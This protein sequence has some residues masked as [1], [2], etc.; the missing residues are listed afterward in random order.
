M[1]RLS[2]TAIG[3]YAL[4][5]L[6]AASS[7]SAY[8]RMTA[9]QRAAGPNECITEGAEL[10]WKQRC[11]SYSIFRAGSRDL[12]M[13]QL[14]SVMRD[15]FA[16]WLRATCGGQTTG[17]IVQETDALSMST[18]T[19]FKSTGGNVNNIIFYDDWAERNY[20]P[21]AYALTIVW[22]N[23]RTGEIYDADM[24]INEN[25]GTYA[26]CPEPEGCV[27]GRI[28]LQNVVTHEAGHFLGL[29]HSVGPESFGAT[30][31][32]VAPPGEVSKRTLEQDDINGLCDIYP[33]GNLP[34]ACDFTPRGGLDLSGDVTDDGSCSVAATRMV[35]RSERGTGLPFALFIVGLGAVGTLWLRRRR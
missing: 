33:P 17:L 20:D 16:P 2:L 11:I 32:A 4:V 10:E 8:C 26:I 34:D 5:S 30:M 12:T 23:T 19:E 1:I 7:V 24:A 9:S 35:R 29:A 22:H 27:D 25:R 31:V 28:D 3:L 15:S 13:P 18:K 6:G 21:M 14:Q